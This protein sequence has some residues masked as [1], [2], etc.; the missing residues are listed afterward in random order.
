MAKN[1]RYGSRIIRYALIAGIISSLA[2]IYSTSTPLTTEW[3]SSGVLWAFIINGLAFLTV[4]WMLAKRKLMQRVNVLAAAMDRGAEGDLTAKVPVTSN[5]EL[6]MLNRNFNAMM[7]KLAGMTMRVNSSIGEL[8]L[9]ADNIKEVSHRGVAAAELQLTG[10][11]ETSGAVQEINRS[12][13]GVAESVASLSRSAEEN[14]SSI[15]EM[16]ASVDEVIGHVEALAAAVEEVS[17]SIIEMAA[18]EKKIGENVKSLKQEATA[19]AS[20]VAVLDVSIKQVEKNALDTAAISLNVRHDAESGR[21]AVEATISGI[22]EIRRSARITFEVIETLSARADDIGNILSVID[23]VAEQTNLLALNASII[24]AQAG[25]RG[26]GFAVVAEEIKD[27][28]Q[29]TSSS[30]REITDIIKGVQDETRRAVEAI[31]QS[32][33]R[34]ADGEQVAQRSGEA[35][36]KIVAGVQMATDQ[37]NEIANTTVEQAKGSQEM[38]K[39][40]ERVAEM[41]GQISRSTQDQEREGDLIKGHAE[42]MKELTRQVRRSTQEQSSAGKTIVRSTEEI[43]SMIESIRQACDDQTESSRRIIETMEQIRRSAETGEE[44]TI[45]MEGAVSGLS[46]QIGLL[47]KEMSGFRLR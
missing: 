18:M 24:A 26:K 21:E 47:Q 30:T 40:M 11:K 8:R 33:R 37:V 36:N 5:D 28:A 9:I 43:T 12:V 44:T 23:E 34:I 41:V 42:R 46:R 32:E 15:L 38:R 45:V 1:L 10:A 20:R 6:E 13:N 16:S 22:G 14:A 19:A 39:A 17:A 29:R 27:L 7:E 25:E 35:L 31:T 4:F 3:R 2:G